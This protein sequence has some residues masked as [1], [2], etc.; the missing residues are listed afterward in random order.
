[1]T[2]AEHARFLIPKHV[3]ERESYAYTRPAAAQSRCD[4]C[5]GEL[6][7][8]QIESASRILELDTEIFVCAK[9]GRERG[10]LEMSSACEMN[11]KMQ[12]TSAVQLA[13]RSESAIDRNPPIAA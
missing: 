10:V 9:C 5:G 1:M 3:G 13:K 11:H 4:L 6:R 12:M 2:A 8:K 7:L